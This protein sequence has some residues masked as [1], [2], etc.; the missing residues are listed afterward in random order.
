MFPV[1]F[2]PVIVVKLLDQA[3]TISKP[4][5]DVGDGLRLINSD[6]RTGFGFILCLLGWRAGAHH[7]GCSAE[8]RE[9][10]GELLKTR[11]L[12][13]PQGARSGAAYHLLGP[14][15]RV[16]GEETPMQVGSEIFRSQLGSRNLLM[17][18]P[19]PSPFVAPHRGS[20]HTRRN[21]GSVTWKNWN[22]CGMS[23]ASKLGIRLRPQKG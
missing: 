16:P 3:P 23:H 7:L 10:Q 13:W 4:N 2:V 11:R 17:T 15:T 8:N 19:L 5:L 21:R 12:T 6:G 22:R 18:S 1:A 20:S 14:T 9:T